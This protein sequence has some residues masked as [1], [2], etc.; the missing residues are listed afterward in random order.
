MKTIFGHG[1]IR[2]FKLLFKAL[3]Y[4]K[5]G[6]NLPRGKMGLISFLIIVSLM[7]AQS[8]I[9]QPQISFSDFEYFVAADGAFGLYKPKGW[10]VGTQKYTDGKMIYVTDAKELAYV[11]LI[12]LEKIDPAHDSVSFA[13]ATL[14][15]I[16]RQIPDLKITMA[17]TSR[18]R[19]KTV[20]EM[21][22]SGA[23]QII[24]KSKYTFHINRP[25]ALIIGYEAPA[26]QFK[27]MVPTLMTIVANITLFDEQAYKK[28]SGRKG[29]V[30]SIRPMHLRRAP[31]GTCEIL[32]PEGWELQA[33][34]G[35]A[36]CHGQ[37][38]DIGYIFTIIDFVGQSQ[39]PYFSSSQIPGNLRYSYMPPGEALSVAMSHYGSRNLRI[40]ERY[41][42]PQ[43]AQQTSMFLK[44]RA[45]AENVLISFHSKRGTSCI[46]YYDV[47]GLH[48][49]YAG[50][51]GIIVNGF[52]APESSFG[53]DLPSLI[54]IAE[55][56]KINEQWA[57][58]YVR[59]GMERLKE[60]M[61]KTSS[62]M[63]RYAEEMRQ[64]SLAAHQ[65]RM[66]SSDFI[67]YKF[68]TY[69]RGEQEWVTALEGGQIYKS[70]HWG[71]SKEGQTIIEGQPF[72]YYN[73][74][75][76]Y[77]YGHIPVDISREVYEAVKSQP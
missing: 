1:R 75:G 50:Q 36:L 47:L 23:G 15:N 21:Q 66:K 26:N 70:D 17:R 4:D 67:N 65:N 38:G 7:W 52:W 28:M 42:N 9:A 72:N 54:K 22:R 69:M 39:I 13:K 62:M 61:K 51:W 45:D 40:I 14:Q 32:V 6:P 25:Q 20:V 44:R 30:A 63:S 33:A 34:K 43:V 73:Y 16:K 2:L 12:F 11:N 37:G 48:P 19:L 56:Y 59:Q 58:E 29:A 24:I 77:Q 8:A 68:S 27:E 49:T 18:D 60:L 74:K 55:S 3:S 35:A 64:S 57:R 31:D 71:L 5:L 10:K 41:P 53:Q 46:G 76:D